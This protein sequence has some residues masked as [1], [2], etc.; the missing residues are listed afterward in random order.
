[1]IV[2]AAI[3]NAFGLRC[4]MILDEEGVTFVQSADEIRLRWDEITAIEVGGDARTWEVKIRTP[5]GEHRP[6]A[7]KCMRWFGQPK[8]MR[9]AVE[10]L[11]R[12][13]QAAAA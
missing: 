5:T 2:G 8:S 7:L 6:S 1:M 13:R 10:T 9:R 11:E 3:G 4:K 12:H